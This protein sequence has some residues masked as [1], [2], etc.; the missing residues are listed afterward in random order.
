MLAVSVFLGR[1]ERWPDQTVE[2]QVVKLPGQATDHIQ[3]GTVAA[4]FQN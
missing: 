1:L 4:D 2:A 3:S